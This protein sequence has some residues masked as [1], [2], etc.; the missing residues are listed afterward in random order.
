MGSGI[1]ICSNFGIGDQN[2][3]SK[4]GIR[5]EKMYI[6][7]TLRCNLPCTLCVNK[8]KLKIFTYFTCISLISTT[9]C[10]RPPPVR[11]HFLNYIPWPI[12]FHKRCLFLIETEQCFELSKYVETD[13]AYL[14]FS[15]RRYVYGIFKKTVFI[16]EQNRN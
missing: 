15:P 2:L 12:L 11:G 10:K 7:T 1:K 4:C 16:F 3:R 6:V 13:H 8:T 5:W 9:F 14:V